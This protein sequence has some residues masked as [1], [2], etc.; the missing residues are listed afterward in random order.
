MVFVIRLRS[1]FTA[2]LL[3]AFIVCILFL[4]TNSDYEQKIYET[5]PVSK[6]LEEEYAPV[7]KS[8]IQMRNSAML[9]YDTEGIKH[10][11]DTGKRYG[12]WAFEHEKKKIEYLH[13]WAEKQGVIFTDINS[14]FIIKWV[15]CRTAL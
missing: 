9:N 10:L 5:I 6:E 2:S 7:I 13:N 14:V 8:F 11:Y 4:Y 3:L 15:K 12:I 1:F